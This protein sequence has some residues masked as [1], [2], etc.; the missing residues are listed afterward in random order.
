MIS[1]NRKNAILC[2]G[3]LLAI[4]FFF[5]LRMINRSIDRQMAIQLQKIKN[6]LSQEI[7]AQTQEQITK[8]QTRALVPSDLT[9]Y[10]II[11]HRKSQLFK[12]QQYWDI[13]T[14]EAVQHSAIINNKRE[15]EILEG[16][17][18]SPKEF[19]KKIQQIDGRIREYKQII[20]DNPND[21]Y[22]KQKLQNLYMIKSTVKALKETIV[23][24]N[25]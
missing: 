13:L 14:R 8:K 21:E 19:K 1:F 25:N 10:Q 15:S 20:H 4:V 18:E 17:T 23:P 11:P 2:V 9:N 24:A 3:L 7:P 16:I 6:E 12:N 5:S 22:A